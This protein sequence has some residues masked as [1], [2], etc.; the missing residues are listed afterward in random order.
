MAKQRLTIYVDEHVLMR[1]AE[2]RAA[3]VA[4][5][6]AAPSAAQIINR[7]LERTL[8]PAPTREGTA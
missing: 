1:V 4:A 3:A 2:L 5:T 6:G 8:A 7:H